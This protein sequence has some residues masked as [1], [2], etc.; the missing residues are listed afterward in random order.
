M[1][2]EI[3]CIA[4]EGKTTNGWENDDYDFIQASCSVYKKIM[5]ILFPYF[6]H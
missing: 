3:C 1:N 4:Y 5:T 6:A 2:E